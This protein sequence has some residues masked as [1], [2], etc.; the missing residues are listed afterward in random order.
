MSLS[1]STRWPGPQE[2]RRQL[3][4]SGCSDSQKSALHLAGAELISVDS[5]D[6]IKPHSKEQSISILPIQRCST[7]NSMD[8]FN[9]YIMLHLFGAL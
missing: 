4:D 7:V 6:F 2:Q 1:S 5:K 3:N 8:H 9:Q